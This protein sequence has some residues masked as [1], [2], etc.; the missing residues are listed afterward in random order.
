MARP[1]KPAE[2]EAH[3]L[4]L[5]AGANRRYATR[6]L[7]GNAPLKSALEGALCSRQIFA[8]AHLNAHDKVALGRITGTLSGR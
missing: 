2:A 5:L 8:G 4:Q 1:S 7:A 3:Y 6:L